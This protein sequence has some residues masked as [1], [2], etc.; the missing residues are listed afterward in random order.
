[1]H[2][3]NRA[4]PTKMGIAPTTVLMT[5]GK[6]NFRVFDMNEYL[7]EYSRY[8]DKVIQASMHPIPTK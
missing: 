3:P 7:G 1:M 4:R 2:I 5:F 8:Y 6:A